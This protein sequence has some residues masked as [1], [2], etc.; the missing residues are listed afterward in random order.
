MVLVVPVS[1]RSAKAL[2]SFLCGGALCIFHIVLG[3][4]TSIVRNSVDVECH[5]LGHFLNAAEPM[6]L[7]A[8]HNYPL[9]LI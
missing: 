3:P 5:Q 8:L 4:V 6:W 2:G 1:L 9:I 7:V